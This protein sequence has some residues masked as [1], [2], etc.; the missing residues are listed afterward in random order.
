M[1]MTLS[2]RERCGRMA[3]AG[4]ALSTVLMFAQ[5]ESSTVLP[6]RTAP[7]ETLT[8]N[9]GFRDWNP[10]TVVGTTLLGGNRTNRG[11]VVAIDTPSG[12]VKWTYHPVFTSGT[13]S[14]STAPAVSGDTGVKPFAA[15]H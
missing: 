12:K 1:L 2:V 7:T 13:A 15:A 11:G 9:P 3:T 8:V 14:V 10:T 6:L 4:V 5:S